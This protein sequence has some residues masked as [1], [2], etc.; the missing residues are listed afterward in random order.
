MV[1]RY[2]LPVFVGIGLL[3]TAVR[4]NAVGVKPEVLA[5]AVWTLAPYAAVCWLARGTRSLARI[6]ALIVLVVDAA[7]VRHLVRRPPGLEEGVLFVVMPAVLLTGIG[8]LALLR[9]VG[10]AVRSLRADDGT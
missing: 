2:G 1:D 7:A 3:L 10:D 4:I 8:L 6:A 9:A 5:L